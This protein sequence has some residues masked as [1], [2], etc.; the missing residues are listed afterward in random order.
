MATIEKTYAP[1][2]KVLIDSYESQ[3]DDFHADANN[4]IN[5]V[6]SEAFEFFQESGLPTHKDEKW[7]NSLL[8]KGYN[9][10]YH[11]DISATPFE[12]SVSEIFECEIHGY[13]AQVVSMLNGR[14]YDK[15]ADSLQKLENGV[16]IGS[17]LVAQRELPELFNKHFGMIANHKQDGFSAINSALFKDGVFIYVPDGVEV[18]KAIQLIKMINRDEKLMINARNLIVLGRN[19]KVSFMHCDDSVNHFSAFINTLTE[20]YVGENASLDLYKMQNINNDTSLLNNTYIYQERNS[21]TKVNVITLNG[22]KIRNELHVNLDGEGAETDL[23]GI[24]LMDNKQHIDNQ[25]FVRHSVPNCYSSELFKGV[26]DDEASAIFNGYIYV[27]RDAQQTNAFQ[28]NNNILMTPQAQI[29]TM[30]FLEIYADDVKCSHGATVGQLDEDALFYLM[31]RG[32][33]RDDAR[34][35]LMY[36]FASEVTSKIS[37]D[38]LRNSF[39]DMIKKRLR[40][41]LSIC[42]KCVLHC[43]VPEN[44]IEFEIDM[45]KV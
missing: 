25:V 16:V 20:I 41:E 1:L 12:K 17:I 36:A 26:L 6:R 37:I 23:N 27:A 28:R 43:S 38:A 4:N 32:I 11:L 7:R 3:T 22:G 30:P 44:P 18:E 15:N 8:T 42:E 40:G 5:R 29:D 9:E 14:Y 39:E 33:N 35:L 13:H 10:N 24:Y 31:Q 34:L 21:R 19:S 2:E 45:S